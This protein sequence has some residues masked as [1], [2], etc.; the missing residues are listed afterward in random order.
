M[1]IIVAHRKTPIARCF[2]VYVSRILSRN[3]FSDDHIPRMCVATHLVRLSR[4]KSSTALHAGKDF[5]VSPRL[6]LSELFL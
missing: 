3:K 6:L 5:A 2:S 4:P 1:L